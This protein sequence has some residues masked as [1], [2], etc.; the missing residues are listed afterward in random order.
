MIRGLYTAASGMMASMLANDV[1]ADNIANAS[2]AGYKKSQPSFQTFPNMLI[3]KMSGQ[4]TES[5]GDVSTGT[6]VYG[7]WIDFSNGM[8]ATTGNTF[9]LGIQ[10]DG[11]FT[12]Q[13]AS[14]GK[15][16][17]TRAGNFTVDPNGYL[18]TVTG[19]FVMGKL[20][21][22]NMAQ[23]EP[24]FDVNQAGEITAKGRQVDQVLITR[25]EDNRVL[26][27]HGELL[28]E[29]T[30]M[31]KILPPSKDQTQALG[32]TIHQKT[33]ERANVNIVSEMVNSITGMRLY[34]ALQKNIHM[35][36]EILGK[37]VNEVG[38]YR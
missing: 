34:E 7:T 19:D 32:Y 27:K 14:D 28:Y 30:P 21:K 37:T 24:P 15:T 22:I 33:L 9:D 35:Q 18:T 3:Q 11:F 12:I 29:A 26:S 38:R 6:R 2:T 4:Q 23:D 31:T 10:G 17:Y 8:L 5:V 16:Y 20:G 36:N 25:F 1:L 13:G